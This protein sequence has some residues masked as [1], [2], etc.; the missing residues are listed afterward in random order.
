MN[1]INK[2]NFGLLSVLVG[3]LTWFNYIM[4]I[5]NG[6]DLFSIPLLLTF[7]PTIFFGVIG[8]IRGILGDGK[9]IVL[10]IFGILLSFPILITA[11]YFLVFVIA[12]LPSL[13]FG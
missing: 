8:L 9:H 10:S 3:L 2:I 5:K 13:L 12:Y 11:F 4:Q 6:S 7:I 1:K